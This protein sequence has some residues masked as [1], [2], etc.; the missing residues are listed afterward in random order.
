M[1]GVD[2]GQQLA[3]RDVAARRLL[4]WA[5][6]QSD[7]RQD[8]QENDHPEGEV[9]KI[10]VHRFPIDSAAAGMSRADADCPKPSFKR[11]ECKCQV[12]GMKLN[13]E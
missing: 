1:A 3:E 13:I 11:A 7:Q 8:E 5:L 6:E 2:L 10:R 9:T 12:N 4:R